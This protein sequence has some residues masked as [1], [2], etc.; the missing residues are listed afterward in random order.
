MNEAKYTM[1]QG[2]LSSARNHYIVGAIAVIGPGV[3]SRVFPIGNVLFDKY[4]GDAL[5]AVLIYLALRMIQP[6]RPPRDHANWAMVV[7][8]AIELFQ[9][10]GMPLAL[11][12]SGNG[13][14]M[15]FSVVLGTHFS[16]LDIV[17]YAVGIL[18]IY[19]VD[20]KMIKSY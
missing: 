11:R 4:L 5:Y 6:Q 8:F 16:W 17:A 1:K 3:I 15:L 13:V 12:E 19:W 7:A 14:L 2:T 18:A 10:T 9:L 20:T